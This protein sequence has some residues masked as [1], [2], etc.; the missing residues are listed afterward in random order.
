MGQ[1]K[2]IQGLSELLYCNSCKCTLEMYDLE[3]TEGDE[4]WVMPSG[5]GDEIILCE[6]CYAAKLQK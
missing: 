4:I 1:Q 5:T 2:K 6:N 3:D